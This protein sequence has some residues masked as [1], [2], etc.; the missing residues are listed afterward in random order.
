MEDGTAFQNE[1]TLVAELTATYSLSEFNFL[2]TVLPSDNGLRQSLLW[3]DCVG[4]C[5]D[6]I[7]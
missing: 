7:L 3:S 2:K 5:S 1:S 4:R 6:N